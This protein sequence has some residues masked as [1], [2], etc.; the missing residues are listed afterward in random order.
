MDDVG[1]SVYEGRKEK[2]DRIEKERIHNNKNKEKHGRE[3]VDQTSPA[4]IF[5]LSLKG[6][7]GQSLSRF[8]GA[9][10][11]YPFSRGVAAGEGLDSVGFQWR[12]R[13]IDNEKS[14]LEEPK[15]EKSQAEFRNRKDFS[16]WH[17]RMGRARLISRRYSNPR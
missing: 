14:S 12:R 13:P 16:C 6:S 1:V 3:N 11:K 17:C 10:R 2:R 5:I 4:P 7:A 9:V 8:F 15:K